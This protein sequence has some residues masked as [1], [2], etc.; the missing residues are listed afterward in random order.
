MQTVKAISLLASTL[1]PGTQAIKI[2]FTSATRDMTL[3]TSGRILYVDDD[4]VRHFW[5]MTLVG[6]PTTTEAVMQHVVVAD[7]LNSTMVD[8]SISLRGLCTIDGVERLDE[9]VP[10]LL[11]VYA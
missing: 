2:R 3:A 4:D 7:D 5:S 1:C 9:A 6:T 11:P 8:T 10:F